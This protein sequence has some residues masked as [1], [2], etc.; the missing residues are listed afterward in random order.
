V[1]EE[2][3]GVTAALSIAR[4]LAT[5]EEARGR[6]YRFLGYVPSPSYRTHAKVQAVEGPW[7]RL[8]LPEWHPELFVT[9]ASGELPAA[10]RSPGAWM[11]CKANL[12]AGRPVE[13][14]PRAMAPAATSFD[15]RRYPVA[16]A[17]L[18]S[19]RPA[20]DDVCPPQ[21]GRDCGDVVLYLASVDLPN[22]RATASSVYVNGHPPPVRPGGRAYLYADGDVQGW[23]EVCGVAPLPNGTRVSFA[24]GF[25]RCGVP[26]PPPPP[27]A[28]VVGGRHGTQQWQWRSWLRDDEAQ[29]GA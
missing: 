20:L 25:T 10:C 28:S 11:S 23:R 7:A 24:P 18:D 16:T 19:P 13:V 26:D 8:I 27:V 22:D 4:L 2:P 1:R 29:T 9:V 6:H 21:L 14:T 17:L 3:D 12:G 15:P 5:D